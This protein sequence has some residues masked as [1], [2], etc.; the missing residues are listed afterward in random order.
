MGTFSVS[1]PQ[2]GVFFFSSDSELAKF[3]GKLQTFK[4]CEIGGL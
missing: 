3:L 1:Q 2:K 4:G